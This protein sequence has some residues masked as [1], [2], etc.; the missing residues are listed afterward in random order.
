MR[1]RSRNCVNVLVWKPSSSHH[2]SL[3]LL[4]AVYERGLSTIN[5]IATKS[6]N[7]LLVKRI[8]NLFFLSLVYPPQAKF[9]PAKHVKEWLDCRRNGD[10]I[11]GRK[12]V[13][14]III[15]IIVLPPVA[16]Q[17]NCQCLAQPM[18]IPAIVRS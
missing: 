11:R 4:T 14:C 8:S 12:I 3:P 10:D 15:I 16:L 5:I 18:A 9:E 7:R 2:E 6:G 13:E 17:S 1:Q